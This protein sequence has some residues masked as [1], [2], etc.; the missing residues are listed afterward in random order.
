MSQ[1]SYLY[2]LNRAIEKFKNRDYDSALM[3]LNEALQENY[4][5]PQLHYWI[6]KI[7][8]E[9]LTEEKLK[10]AVISFTE[11]IELKPDYAEALFER[12][13]LY[14]KMGEVEKAINDLER[15]IEY[16]L[17]DEDIYVHLSK[18]YMLKGDRKKALEI[19]R[20]TSSKED[21][22]FLI[23]MSRV[24]I[25]T[26]SYDEAISYL[27]KAKSIDKND[28][29]IYELLAEAYEGK[30]EYLKAIEALKSAAFLNPSE[31]QYF[32]RI[33]LNFVKQAELENE[34][35]NVKKAGKYISLAVDVDY[36]VPLNEEHRSL[37]KNAIDKCLSEG[38]PKEALSF[39]D[40]IE[41]MAQIDE[42]I[43]ELK[44][45]AFKELPLKEKI[46]RLITDIYT[47]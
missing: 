34:K 17:K 1:D 7:Y 12:G 3:L 25:S 45:K 30:K 47:K 22:K 32:K 26:K 11:A 13:K 37:L 40:C 14:L 29:E 24:L 36:D 6:G 41:R 31:E 43:L 16:G 42:E 44:K 10:T 4:D 46:V 20:E 28:V 18:A 19:L 15:A 38:K 35:G 27:E 21:N 5:V 39:I 33:A 2:Y 8:A 23:N 9:E